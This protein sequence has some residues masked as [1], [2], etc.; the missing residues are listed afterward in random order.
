MP[1]LRQ[2]PRSRTLTECASLHT[3]IALPTLSQVRPQLALEEVEIDLSDYPTLT[4]PSLTLSQFKLTNWEIKNI[5][6]LRKGLYCVNILKGYDNSRRCSI[7][8]GLQSILNCIQKQTS[9]SEKSNIVYVEIRSEKADSK[10]NLLKLFI[11]E[12]KQKWV[13]VVGDAKII[14]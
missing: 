5:Q 13:I 7:L 10:V 11:V 9:E 1:T 2:K 4:G 3:Y 12:R 6:N 8:P 14:I